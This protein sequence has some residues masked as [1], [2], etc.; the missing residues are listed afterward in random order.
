MNLIYEQVV[1]QL[2]LK[3]IPHPK[4]YP[5]DWVHDNA[6]LHVSRKYKLQFAI[7]SKFVD[8]V[9]LDVISLD[10]CGRVLGSPYM[11]DRKA[12]FYREHNK[13]HFFK[14]G[15][16]FI[17]K[18]HRMKSDKSIVNT[19]YLKMVVNASK[20]LTLMSIIASDIKHENEMIYNHDKVS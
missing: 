10:I 2:G 9:E 12:I 17:R 16:E 11:Y 13:Y 7:T 6:R 4:L 1:K 18:N 15:I 8:E 5:L 20:T 19:G 14:D 3:T